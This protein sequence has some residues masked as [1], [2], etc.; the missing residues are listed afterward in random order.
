[1]WKVRYLD[2][3]AAGL[4]TTD[5]TWNIFYSGR[6]VEHGRSRFDPPRME[7]WLSVRVGVTSRG[8]HVWA[9]IHYDLR[10]D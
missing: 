6:G 4:D 9:D 2:G 7:I 10:A 1:M 8:S 3:V 5:R